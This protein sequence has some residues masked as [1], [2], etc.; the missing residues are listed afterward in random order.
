MFFIIKL[1]HNYMLDYLFTPIKILSIHL[2]DANFIIIA[3][4]I[5][6]KIFKSHHTFVY[7]Y[8]FRQ[9]L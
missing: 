1:Y 8:S 5:I 6:K 7:N 3:L 2:F 9:C 4:F